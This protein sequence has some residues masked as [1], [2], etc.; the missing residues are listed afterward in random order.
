M[1]H[2]LNDKM[3]HDYIEDIKVFKCTDLTEEFNKPT[4]YL[5]DVLDNYIKYID[6]CNTN[7]ITN[8]EFYYDSTASLSQKES[9]KNLFDSILICADHLVYSID[10]IFSYKTADD[11][12]D[13]LCLLELVV[14]DLSYPGIVTD[15]EYI[16]VLQSICNVVMQFPNR[17]NFKL[18]INAYSNINNLK[19]LNLP[20]AGI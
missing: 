12:I 6:F 13:P 17:Y 15:K 16:N 8:Y 7:N 3:I 1:I 4:A 11:L 18:L 5:L 19:L 2:D 14:K 20:Y 10:S 9:F